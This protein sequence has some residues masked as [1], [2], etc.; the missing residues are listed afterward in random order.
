MKKYIIEDNIDFYKELNCSSTETNSNNTDYDNIC[1]ISNEILCDKYVTME[2]G[3]KFNYIP[4]YKD[5]FKQKYYTNVLEDIK[6]KMNQIR[7][8]YCRNVTT[9]LI[10]FYENFV[11]MKDIKVRKILG[12]NNYIIDN[13]N[14]YHD[15]LTYCREKW[16]WE[17]ENQ[18]MMKYKKTQFN[19]EVK[20]LAKQE[21][22]QAKLEA[23]EQAKK[24]KMEAKEQAK[25]AK[26]EAKLLAKQAKLEAKLLAKKE[27]IF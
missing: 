15:Q 11:I 17:K 10:P 3:H 25:K 21:A 9:S 18:K 20:L 14:V 24:A 7:C 19:Y 23:K 26:E 6:L 5:L 13:Y 27:K 12:V 22:K 16:L 4:L 1:L 2:C 8:P